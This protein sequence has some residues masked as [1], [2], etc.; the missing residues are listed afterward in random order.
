MQF[1]TAYLIF[2]LSL[3]EG[4][5]S[6]EHGAAAHHGH[7]SDLLAPLVNVVVLVGFLVWKLK[8]PLSD[9][10]TKQAEEISNLLE[11]ASLK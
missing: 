4:A 10:F 6:A 2:G 11:R 5:I 1:W 8:K 7:V 9:M 3:I